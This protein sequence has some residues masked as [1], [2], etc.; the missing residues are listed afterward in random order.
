MKSLVLALLVGFAGCHN[1]DNKSTPDLASPGGVTPCSSSADCPSTLPM[2]HPDS[3]I[4]VGCNASFQTCGDGKTCDEQTHTCV[5]ADPNAPCKRNADCPRPGFDPST[6]V[7]CYITADAG[8]CVQ[9]TSN[10]DCVSPDTCHPD[11]TCK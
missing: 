11:Y 8:V 7:V 6:S 4:C 5:P 9:C 10:Q 1:D 3:K 2:C